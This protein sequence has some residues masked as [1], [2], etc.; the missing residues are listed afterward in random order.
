[1]ETERWNH[2]GQGNIE[3]YSETYIFYYKKLFNYGRKFTDD[4]ALIEDGIQV[5]FV[6]IWN[7][8][9]KFVDIS[10][11]HSY[12]FY[13]FRNYIFKEKKKQ[14]KV[15]F[16]NKEPE[17]SI[18]NI[19]IDKE[20]TADLNKRLQVALIS[21]TSRQREAIFLR[22]YEALS[23]EEVAQIMNISVKATYK[24]ITRSL[25]KLKELL[26]IPMILLLALLKGFCFSDMYVV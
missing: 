25:L 20:T 4:T 6:M 3:A 12:I 21:L 11:P 15:V 19:L 8:R 16:Q 24:L 13:S 18:D 7:N 17:F 14:Q 5:V 10:S 23:F 9:E 2:I 22:F 1:L 26:N